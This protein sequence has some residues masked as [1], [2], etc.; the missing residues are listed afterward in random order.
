MGDLSR[1]RG[2]YHGGVYTR[3][4]SFFTPSVPVSDVFV[5]LFFGMASKQTVV[6]IFLIT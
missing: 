4:K 1:G 6:I 5:E 3:Y 2:A